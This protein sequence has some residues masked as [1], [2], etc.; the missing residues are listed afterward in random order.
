VSVRLGGCHLAVSESVLILVK[1][2][3]DAEARVT[4]EEGDRKEEFHQMN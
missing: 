1:S 3:K 2:K 4:I